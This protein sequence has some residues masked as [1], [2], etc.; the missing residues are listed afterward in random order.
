MIASVYGQETRPSLSEPKPAR[1]RDRATELIRREAAAMAADREKVFARLKELSP[2]P[3]PARVGVWM[4][5]PGMFEELPT[6][7]DDDDEPDGIAPP[8]RRFIVAKQTFNQYILGGAGDPD[9]RAHLESL[10]SRRIEAIDRQRRLTPAQKTKLLLAGRGDIKRLFDRIE[11]ERKQFELLRTDLRACQLFLREL[12]PLA[13]TMQQGPFDDGSL[14]AKTLEKML[15][16]E[17]AVTRTPM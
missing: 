14:F 4:V 1:F 17:A 8:P 3:A 5:H 15:K 10:L 16:A 2:V 9:S 6:P 7:R 11:D 12:Q 13:Q